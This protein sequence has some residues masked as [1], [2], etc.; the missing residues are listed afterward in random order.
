M[1]YLEINRKAWNERTDTHF[2][3]KMYDVRGFLAGRLLAQGD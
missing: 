1:S 3:S 2:V